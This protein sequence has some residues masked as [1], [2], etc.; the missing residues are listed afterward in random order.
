LAHAA[1]VKESSMNTWSMCWRACKESI[2]WR[3]NEHENVSIRS[4]AKRAGYEGTRGCAAEPLR[5]MGCCSSSSGHE[6][7]TKTNLEPP[8]FGKDINVNLTKQGMFDWD[9][10]V[11][12]S[13]G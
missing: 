6:E 9:F 4:K 2:S 8:M 10:D 12:I 13:R 7:A 5:A 1:L 3:R 11:H